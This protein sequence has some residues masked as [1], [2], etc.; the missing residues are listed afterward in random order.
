M[1]S[2]TADKGGKP[3]LTFVSACLTTLEWAGKRTKACFYVP[4][5]QECMPFR[6]LSRTLRGKLRVYGKNF[7]YYIF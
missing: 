1:T 2:A 6:P 4:E 5:Q 7:I 3:T